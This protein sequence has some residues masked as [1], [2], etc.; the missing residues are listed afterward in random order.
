M[1]GIEIAYGATGSSTGDVTIFQVLSTG[2]A[3]GAIRLCEILYWRSVCCY[4]PMRVLC[5]A[6]YRHSICCYAM[7]STNTAY[8][9]T[10]CA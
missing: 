10:Q 6:R 4:L 5:D 8:A 9:T 3:C 2:I 7:C 1:R